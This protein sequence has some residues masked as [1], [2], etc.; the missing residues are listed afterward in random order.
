MLSLARYLKKPEFQDRNYNCLLMLKQGQT[1]SNRMALGKH[2]FLNL[3]FYAVHNGAPGRWYVNSIE[4]IT[5][6]LSWIQY[7]EDCMNP[8]MPIYEGDL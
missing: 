5:G 7:H 6:A 2:L 8:D 3:G 4:T 1:V